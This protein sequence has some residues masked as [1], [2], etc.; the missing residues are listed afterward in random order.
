MERGEGYAIAHRDELERTGSW[1]LV[2]RSMDCQAFGV[3]L[4]DIPPG[5][6][7]PEHRETE[8]DQEELFYVISGSPALVID[9]QE[10]PAP[11]GT[12]ARLDPAHLRTVRNDGAEPCSVLIVS[13]PTTSGYK[14]MEWA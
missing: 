6:S 14:P 5:E 2:R 11:E 12:F 1:R 10:H 3:N 8:R 7:I 4:V 13:A 9:G